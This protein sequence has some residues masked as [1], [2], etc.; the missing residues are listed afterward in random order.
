MKLCVT[1]VELMEFLHT[2]AN[3][4]DNEREKP[5]Q[6]HSLNGNA[7]AALLLALRIYIFFAD[8]GC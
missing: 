4:D 7:S 5:I 6:F 2:H 3:N 8:G 1:S